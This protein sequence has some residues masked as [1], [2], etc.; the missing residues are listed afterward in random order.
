MEVGD[1]GFEAVGVAVGEAFG[2]LGGDL[3]FALFEG[4]LLVEFA[5][6]GSGVE[7]AVF[8]F[9]H[10][11]VVG[12]VGTGMWM[13]IGEGGWLVLRECGGWGGRRGCV[14]KRSTRSCSE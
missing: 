7:G 8:V 2:A 10:L 5:L 1:L 13:G 12:E 4:F 14:E 6:G 9:G 3:G 11:G